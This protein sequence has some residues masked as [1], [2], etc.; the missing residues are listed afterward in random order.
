MC[1]CFPS[2]P[3]SNSDHE[4]CTHSSLTH[5]QQHSPLPACLS[6]DLSTCFKPL[7]PGGSWQSRRLMCVSVDWFIALVLFDRVSW[8]TMSEGA[9]KLKPLNPI[10]HEENKVHHPSLPSFRSGWFLV[11]RQKAN[12]KKKIL[13]WTLTFF[14]LPVSSPE[15]KI[16]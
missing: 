8:L 14:C 15:M 9:F 1:R 4:L 10:N 13:G 3:F 16:I 12:N 11:R 6:V 2:V 7:S 5:T